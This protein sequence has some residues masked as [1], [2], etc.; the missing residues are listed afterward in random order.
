[1]PAFSFIVRFREQFSFSDFYE[2]LRIYVLPRVANYVHTSNSATYISRTHIFTDAHLIRYEQEHYDRRCA[3]DLVF[4]IWNCKEGKKYRYK[5][6]LLGILK[7]C[8]FSIISNISTTLVNFNTNILHS[9]IVK[10][11]STNF[12]TQLRPGLLQ[13]FASARNSSVWP[14]GFLLSASKLRFTIRTLFT[15]VVDLSRGSRNEQIVLWRLQTCLLWVNAACVPASERFAQSS[16]R[17]NTACAHHSCFL[18]LNLARWGEYWNIFNCNIG[19]NFKI[20]KCFIQFLAL[21]WFYIP[22]INC[23]PFVVFCRFVL[24]EALVSA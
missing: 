5:A 1:M 13:K 20:Y 21:R 22:I 19:I 23:T 3:L 8:I 2:Y 10:W 24:A 16:P 14:F 11:T 7:S 4:Y 9:D 12:L 17:R 18:N 6:F 15:N